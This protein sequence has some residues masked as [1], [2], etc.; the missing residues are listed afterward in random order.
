MPNHLTTIN[1]LV[2]NEEVSQS[3]PVNQTSLTCHKIV[4]YLFA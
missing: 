4:I 1:P 3:Y 2:Q